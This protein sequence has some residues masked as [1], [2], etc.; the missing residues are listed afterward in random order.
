MEERRLRQCG[1][2]GVQWLCFLL[3][4][5]FQLTSTGNQH[6]HRLDHSTKTIIITIMTVTTITRIT[7]SSSLSPWPSPPLPQP[8]LPWP[9][10]WSGGSALDFYSGDALFKSRLA[11]G[12][13]DW[14]F[15]GFPQ[16]LQ[17][18]ARI[19][20]QSG[21]K[22]F[23][24][25]PFQFIS[26]STIWRH[27]VS[28]LKAL[29]NNIQSKRLS[30]QLPRSSLPLPPPFL[31]RRWS[32]GSGSINKMRISARTDSQLPWSVC[33]AGV[34]CREVTVKNY[35]YNSIKA[36]ILLFNEIS[37]LTMEK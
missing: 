24:P 17:T 10:H 36:P 23:L 25:N 26:H 32:Q 2:N 19:V 16:S 27:F 37:I 31:A 34:I 5:T 33:T 8:S 4:K 18:N 15:C 22:R 12:C 3:Q 13:P 20:P 9:S 30:S 29:L 11:L 35:S 7:L 14:G 21:H 28:I 6:H 1:I